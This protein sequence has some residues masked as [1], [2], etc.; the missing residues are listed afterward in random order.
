MLDLPQEYI[1]DDPRFETLFDAPRDLGTPDVAA[2]AIG[3]HLE[4]RFDAAV[5]ADRQQ[6]VMLSGGVDSIVA[7]A[8]LV[9]TT[10][11]GS[12]VAI[13]IEGPF[14]GSDTENARVVARLLGVEHVVVTLS[15]TD[16]GRMVPKLSVDLECDEL[17]EVGAAI[18]LRAAVDALAAPVSTVQLW[19]GD[20]ADAIFGILGRSPISRYA[21]GEALSIAQRNRFRALLSSNRLVPDF[22]ERIMGDSVWK[23]Y[24][25][26][27]AAQIAA[28][29]H[30]DALFGGPVPKESLRTLA[31]QL[32]VPSELARAPKAAMQESSGVFAGLVA[33][34]RHAVAAIPDAATY[35]DPL[36]EPI[37]QS[38]VRLWLH[39]I[40]Q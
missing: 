11:V 34:A 15:E 37:E 31:E 22:Y 27:E 24:G 21:T 13:T 25:T 23:A 30:G 10:S 6:V 33:L 16:L 4:E 19:T 17:W 5:R 29:M 18:V 9:R 38:L 39:T 7:L 8:A 40:A 2:R 1:A 26:F 28:R 14:G 32:G 3:V 35:R 20:Q 36:E 12:V